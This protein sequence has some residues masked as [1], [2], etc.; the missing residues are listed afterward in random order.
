[1]VPS[2][3]PYIL[4]SFSMKVVTARVDPNAA[5]QVTY[6]EKEFQY[7]NDWSLKGFLPSS[8]IIFTQKKMSTHYITKP[9][10]AVAQSTSD[11]LPVKYQNILPRLE[12][13]RM[14][15]TYVENPPAER[16]LTIS[17]V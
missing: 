16:V 15:E 12:I 10:I 14:S 11:K 9:T 7:Q 2:S 1:M 4:F 6:V 3:S 13:M 5:K 8:V 17:T